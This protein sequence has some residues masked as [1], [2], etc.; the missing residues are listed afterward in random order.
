MNNFKKLNVWKKAIELATNIYK[1]TEY[2]PNDELYGLTSQ[3]RRCTVSISS[4]IAEGAGRQSKKEFRHFLNI[5]AGS[6]NEL[7][8]QLII[9]SNLEYIEEAN[10]EHL[11][12]SIIEIRKMLYALKSSIN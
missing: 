1:E 8:T 3:I 7:E 9:S 6:C 10:S 5:A 2:F 11:Q 12:N 4:N